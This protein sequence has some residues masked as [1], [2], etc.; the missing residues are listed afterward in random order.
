MVDKRFFD[1]L[2]I[3]LT[4]EVDN[5]IANDLSKELLRR[6]LAA[7]ISIRE[8][9]SN[10]WWEGAIETAME[11]QLIIKTSK[12]KLQDLIDAIDQLHSYETPQILFWNVSA[13]HSYR[14]WV[15]HSLLLDL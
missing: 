14:K 15:D 1:D 10:F 13:S 5:T 4:S 2:V 11:S 6:K 9:A 3:L 8:V 12:E 7:C